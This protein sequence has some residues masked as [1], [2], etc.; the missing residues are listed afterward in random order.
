MHN[1]GL[2]TVSCTHLSRSVSYRTL[3]SPSPWLH[4]VLHQVLQPKRSREHSS[5]T[6]PDVVPPRLAARAAELSVQGAAGSAAGSSVPL[7]D[8]AWRKLRAQKRE[9]LCVCYLLNQDW[10]WMPSL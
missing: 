9:E 5:S 6:D 8:V 3:R 1:H 10:L 2:C 4:C 7:D